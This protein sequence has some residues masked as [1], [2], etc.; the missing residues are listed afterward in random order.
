M[1]NVARFLDLQSKTL[2]LAL[3]LI[4]GL[5]VPL[6]IGLQPY[7][8][9]GQDASTLVQ[10][11]AF[12]HNPLLQ[13]NYL[14]L[15]SFPI[16]DEGP[17]FLFSMVVQALEDF[18][19][20]IVVVQQIAVSILVVTAGFGILYLLRVLNMA[21]E[22]DAEPLPF[23][24]ALLCVS[25]YVLNPYSLSV[26]WW[27][28]EG[29]TFLYAFAPF[30]VALMFEFSILPHPKVGNLLGVTALGLALAP[31]VVGGFSILLGYVIVFATVMLIAQLLWKRIRL[32]SFVLR[33]S[34]IWAAFLGFEL[35]F[36]IPYLSI[37]NYAFSSSSY[38]TYSNLMNQFVNTSRGA[39]LLNVLS[40]RGS[41]WFLLNPPESSYPWLSLTSL[42]TVLSLTL[43]VLGGTVLS[44]S[45]HRRRLGI[46]IILFMS[47]PVVW[48]TG[49][50]P[51]LSA[52]KSYL[53][54][55]HGPFLALLEAY[56]SV[57]TLY[58][59]GLIGL[60]FLVVSNARV[61]LRCSSGEELPPQT[62]PHIVDSEARVMPLLAWS[63]VH[64]RI[65][66]SLNGRRIA[67]LS[68]I[69]AMVVIGAGFA[70]PFVTGKVYKTEGPNSGAFAL[71]KSFAQLSNFFAQNYSGPYYYALLIP[72]SSSAYVPLNLSHAE[73]LD[74]TGLIAQY[75]PYP[76]IWINNS[77]LASAMDS[78]FSL[79]SAANYTLMLSALHIR[80][81]IFNPYANESDPAIA[82]AGNNRIIDWSA[83]VDSLRMTLPVAE[84]GRFSVFENFAAQ[85]LALAT[86]EL[87]SFVDP[88]LLNYLTTLSEIRTA[89]VATTR[90]IAS[91]QWAPQPVV[92]VPNATGYVP[93]LPSVTYSI[94][95][96]S[97]PYLVSTEGHLISP[98]NASHFGIVGVTFTPQNHM[99]KIAS[100]PICN[101]NMSSCKFTSNF[102][103]RN[104]TYY[105]PI[106]RTSQL[107]FPS[108]GS[109][110]SLLYGVFA[111]D[112]LA[113]R[114]WLSIVLD[115]QTLQLSIVIYANSTS[116][117]RVFQLT[118]VN[119]VGVA[120][121][122]NNVALPN[123]ILPGLVNLTV[124][125]GPSVI[126]ATLESISRENVTVTD[127]LYYQPTEVT[128]NGGFNLSARPSSHVMLGSRTVQVIATHME[129]AVTN[130]G[131]YQPTQVSRVLELP[132]T[133]QPFSNLPVSLSLT[134]TGNIQM[135]IVQEPTRLASYIILAY[136]ANSLWSANS[137]DCKL[138]PVGG[139]PLANIFSIGSCSPSS[140]TVEV[141]LTF[142]VSIAAGLFIGVVLFAACSVA[143]IALAV[144]WKVKHE[145]RD[146]Y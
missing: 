93:S 141:A 11:F 34:A 46:T 13:Y 47:V 85:P 137:P 83:V 127:L 10:P 51:P 132:A 114:N 82:R 71:P 48:A 79:G 40:L 97:D 59:I 131:E 94:P 95:T 45:G 31:G 77:A 125:V 107:T 14:F 7:F 146:H 70:Y 134:I 63:R 115:G 3:P 145:N 118:A 4:L 74:T 129:V 30:F 84:V 52:I 104:G 28:I 75:I 135:S 54:S 120:Y 5:T 96:G 32:S 92:G 37:P 22:A 1:A 60:A 88:S 26:I 44:T 39:T 73:I 9:F 100:P 142:D 108:V 8:L 29:W 50:N 41:S 106:N 105:N 122:W 117:A 23:W 2:L 61:W 80:F 12:S 86:D 17:Y 130:F 128:R 110:G 68:I 69:T 111:I 136:P 6:W 58:V 20:S 81:V 90:Q 42:L 123:S 35:Y 112:A 124:E 102:V 27:R 76:L 138:L 101:L 98:E 126:S 62:D 67:G 113:A 89:P 91:A 139:F 24:L 119:S 65:P 16:P 109:N 43:L 116:G 21:F 78:L 57:E 36:L 87:S 99:L 56:N 33:V 49:S 18:T 72:L 38:I 133:S 140:T 55:L 19:P 144:Y 103:V 53:L 25:I 143:F 121:A 64:R 66:S 15:W